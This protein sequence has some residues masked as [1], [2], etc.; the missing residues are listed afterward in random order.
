ME[1]YK[2]HE[3]CWLD[4]CNDMSMICLTCGIRVNR[5]SNK[6]EIS[7]AYNEMIIKLTK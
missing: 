1:D 4:S 6:Q 3:H 2:E 7:Q 5:L